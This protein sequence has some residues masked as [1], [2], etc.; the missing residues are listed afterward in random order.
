METLFKIFVVLILSP[1]FAQSSTQAAQ[2]NVF[3]EGRVAEKSFS[4]I[5]TVEISSKGTTM[6]YSTMA[7]PELDLGFFLFAPNARNGFA[8]ILELDIQLMKNHGVNRNDYIR[9]S[10]RTRINNRDDFAYTESLDTD[11]YVRKTTGPQTFQFR[12]KLQ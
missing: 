6:R 9:V 2:V 8:T 12:C 10:S 3:C 5:Q 7:T 4:R 1:L 11:D